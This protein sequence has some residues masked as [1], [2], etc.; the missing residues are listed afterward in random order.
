MT[1]KQIIGTIV[2]TLVVKE[3][4]THEVRVDDISL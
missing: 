4:K 2:A 3:M 1:L